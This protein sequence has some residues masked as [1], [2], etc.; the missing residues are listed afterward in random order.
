MIYLFGVALGAR[1]WRLCWQLRWQEVILWLQT[2]DR[3][4]ANSSLTILGGS[5]DVRIDNAIQFLSGGLPVLPG[6]FLDYP[7]AP[8]AP[9]IL[10]SK[11][12]SSKNVR[13]CIRIQSRQNP[14]KYPPFLTARSA[15]FQMNC[16]AHLSSTK[17]WN[18][19]RIDDCRRRRRSGRRG[20]SIS[21]M[22]R[23]GGVSQ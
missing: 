19:H 16:T 20:S 13:F 10:S 18:A 3:L 2:L 9:G 12:I 6:N 4:L 17:L 22:K 8:R 23:T 21:S 7:P 5:S 15:K 11:Y 1:T 14:P